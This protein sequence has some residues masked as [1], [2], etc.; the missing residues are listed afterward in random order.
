MS[1]R[2]AS[3]QGCHKP[4]TH[5]PVKKES[6]MRLWQMYCPLQAE[7]LRVKAA[8]EKG[9]ID[10]AKVGPKIPSRLAAAPQ[11]HCHSAITTSI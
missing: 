9:N 2:S 11:S 10:I 8:I 1:Q 6:S 5:V 3:T 7:K 4:A